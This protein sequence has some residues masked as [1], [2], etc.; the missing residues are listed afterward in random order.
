ML[1]YLLVCPAAAGQLLLV[2]ITSWCNPTNMP[3]PADEGDGRDLRDGSHIGSTHAW[4]CLPESHASQAL[5]CP[6]VSFCVNHTACIHPAAT[7]AAAAGGPVYVSDRPGQ[8]DF[9]ILRRLVLPD[10]SVLRCQLPGRPTPD[11]LLCDVS[12][13]GKTVLKVR[14]RVA[15]IKV[16]IPDCCMTTGFPLQL[17]PPRSCCRSALQLHAGYHR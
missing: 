12:R 1:P 11:C 2:G 16:E 6:S 10:G 15:L 3:I 8:H 13:D 4:L 17:L 7:A 9:D 5:G 14:A